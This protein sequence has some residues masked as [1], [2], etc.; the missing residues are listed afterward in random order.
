MLTS[1]WNINILLLEKL[2]FRVGLNE[3]ANS[4]FAT[5]YRFLTIKISLLYTA[6][7]EIEQSP[8]ISVKQRRCLWK[9][10]NERIVWE[11]LS[12]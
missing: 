1:T 4:F 5:W 6:L 9:W 11:S 3:N 12:K 2:D 10:I 8:Q 7:I